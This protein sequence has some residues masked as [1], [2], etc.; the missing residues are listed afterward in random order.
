LPIAAKGTCEICVTFTPSATGTPIFTDTAV[1]S[2][3]SVKLAGT[4]SEAARAGKRK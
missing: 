2:P 3:Q 4:G 1:K